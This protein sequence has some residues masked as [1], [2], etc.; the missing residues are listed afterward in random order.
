MSPPSLQSLVTS[1]AAQV[2]EKPEDLSCEETAVLLRAL[3]ARN[4]E[5]EQELQQNGQELK[6]AKDELTQL[7][8]TLYLIRPLK[9]DERLSEEDC[10]YA[11]SV[12]SKWRLEPPPDVV[13]EDTGE[14]PSNFNKWLIWSED[15]KK[16]VIGEQED[17]FLRLTASCVIS[18][19]D[20]LYRLICLFDCL[21]YLDPGERYKCIWELRL[22]HYKTGCEIHIYEHK[23]FANINRDYNNHYGRMDAESAADYLELVNLICSNR[24]PHTYDECKAGS[25]A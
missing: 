4:A 14:A 10:D 12:A 17:L 6:A 13:L 15:E 8:E 11:E 9:F 2:T 18:S 5:L 7:R 24:V 21:S 19:Q 16:F 20:L 1:T 23:G 25:I 3:K 22:W